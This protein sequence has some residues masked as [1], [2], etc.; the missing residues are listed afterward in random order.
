MTE[1]R[2]LRLIGLFESLYHL[3]INGQSSYY[4]DSCPI[5]RRKWTAIC[6]QCLRAR[7]LMMR[8]KWQNPNHLLLTN[9]ALFINTNVICAMQIMWAIR[10]DA[11]I[12]QRINEHKH[13]VIGKHL[14]DVH[15]LR[16]KDL[17]DQF[18]IL[19]KCRRKLDCLTE[20]MKC[21]SSKTENRHLTLNLTPSK[22]NFLSDS[23]SAPPLYFINLFLSFI[24]RF[25]LLNHMH[26]DLHTYFNYIMNS[27][28][29][30]F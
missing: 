2:R 25:L 23:S 30:F 26:W 19:K 22:Q 12:T 27:Q 11:Y 6:A 8:S 3:K 29:H 21:S 9:N 5:S 24:Y 20:F 17:R 28:M 1:N 16:K 14:R 7:K 13:S 18:T 10:A 15:N 4:E